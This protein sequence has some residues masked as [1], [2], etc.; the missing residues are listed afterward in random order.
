MNFFLSLLFALF[1]PS[2]KLKIYIL[3][4]LGHELHKSSYVGFCILWKT[5]L[6]LDEKSKISSFS[7]YFVRGVVFLEAGAVLGRFNILSGLFNL[8]LK[9]GAVISNFCQFKNGGGR[10]VQSSTKFTLG[11]LSKITSG[12]Y[13]DLSSSID[14]GVNCVVGGRDSQFW[15]HGF[16]HQDL[17]ET[18]YI[19]ITGITIGDGVYLG[20]RVTLNPGTHVADNVNILSGSVLSGEIGMDLVIGTSKK[21][22][23][24]DFKN[25]SIKDLYDIDYNYKCGNPRITK[26]NS[27]PS[28]P[29][30]E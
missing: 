6:H 16:I 30:A 7:M 10:V 12:H 21:C 22:V 27:P 9:E 29:M 19:N 17:G 3:N 14:I 8:N 13:F 25:I 1:F 23:I 26:K 15:T 20:S 24:Y 5:K 2:C 11:R 18:R 4:V 28:P